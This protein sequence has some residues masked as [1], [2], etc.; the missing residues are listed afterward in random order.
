MTVSLVLASG[1]SIRRDL[2]VNAGL[3]ID[4]RPVRVDEISIRDAMKAEGA[5]PRDIA[6]ALAEQKARRGSQKSP[7]ALVL[8]CDQV[9]DLDGDILGKPE[10]P[11]D[12]R[13]QLDRLNGTKHRLLSAAVLYRDGQPL[14]RHVGVARLTMRQVSADYL[15]DYVVRNWQSIRHSV[16]GY[17]LEE[18]GVRLFQRIDGDYFTILGLPLLELLGH[19]TVT[20]EIAG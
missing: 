11:Q 10:T 5:P 3:E 2:L 1:S 8:G 17:K 9:L 4:V 18:E 6:D 20:K 16:G 14:W 12:A 7:G 19:L 15:E 13:A